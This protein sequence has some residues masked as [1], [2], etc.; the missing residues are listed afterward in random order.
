VKRLAYSTASGDDPGLPTV[1]FIVGPTAVGKTSLVLE[2]AKTWPL[3]VVSMDSRQ[4]Y[5]GMDI[6]TAKPTRAQREA[7]RHHLVDVADPDEQFDAA[8]FAA[9]SKEVL[10]RIMAEGRLPVVAGG[11]GLYMRALL[12]GFFRGPGRDDVIR[13]KLLSVA[14]EKGAAALHD[15]L[16]RIDPAAARRIHPNDATRLV[17]ALEVYELTGRRISD[18]WKQS[19]GRPYDC[20]PCVV[21]LTTSLQELDARIEQRTG[22]MLER[23]LI[24]EVQSLMEK[25]YGSEL[26]SMS[27]VGYR[28]VAA[29]LRGEVRTEA[30]EGL[31]ARSTRRYARRQLRWFRADAR[32]HW[33]E[34]RDTVVLA[35][36]VT[37]YVRLQAGLPDCVEAAN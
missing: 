23:G 34:A 25:G 11:T 22:R 10:R 14:R 17:R 5:R 37:E 19:P 24:R 9:S 2:L 26:P 16:V 27:A 36:Q 4:V 8:C 7:V 3:E 32:V 6:G 33:I 13:G 35:E 18:L 29:C 30:L 20:S 15:R 1:L 28:E 31:I 12:D 21:G